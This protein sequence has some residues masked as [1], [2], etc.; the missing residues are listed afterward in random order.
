MCLEVNLVPDQQMLLIIQSNVVIVVQLISRTNAQ[1]I[2]QLASNVTK[3]VIIHLNADLA[4]AVPILLKIQGNLPG[5]VV[6]A[7]YLMVENLPQEDKLMKQW[8]SLK[9]SL[10]RNLT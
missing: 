3:L 5:L 2:E 10:M 4:V 1:L 7:E 9:P 6:E 8:R